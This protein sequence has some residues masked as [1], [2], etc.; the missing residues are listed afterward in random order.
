MFLKSINTMLRK[1]KKKFMKCCHLLVSTAVYI[2]VNAV[3]L[4]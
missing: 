1:K 4:T 3:S 2:R